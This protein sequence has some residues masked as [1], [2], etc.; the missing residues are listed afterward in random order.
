[1]ESWECGP[2]RFAVL[3]NVVVKAGKVIKI[4][5]TALVDRVFP[6]SRKIPTPDT[7]SSGISFLLFW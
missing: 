1:M 2:I 7:S 3:Y 5:F 6:E 4:V